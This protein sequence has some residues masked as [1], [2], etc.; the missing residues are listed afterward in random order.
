MQTTNTPKMFDTQPRLAMHTF[1]TKPSP[2][3]HQTQKLSQP[4]P[5]PKQNP[6]HLLL[7]PQF[8]FHPAFLPSV[9]A[10]KPPH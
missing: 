9:P 2:K 5:I 10:K 4:L 3:S 6:P 7:H 1:S 8:Q